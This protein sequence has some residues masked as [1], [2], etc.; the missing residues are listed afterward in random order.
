MERTT[1][2]GEEVIKYTVEEFIRATRP[3]G[4]GHIYFN[5]EHIAEFEEVICDCCNADIVQPE[6]KPKEMV[7]FCVPGAAWCNKCFE[8]LVK[9][10]ARMK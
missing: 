10:G 8:K 2:N 4:L 3:D 9:G 5:G 7:V 6:D 1:I